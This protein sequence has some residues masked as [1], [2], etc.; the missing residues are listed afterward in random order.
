MKKSSRD[1]RVEIRAN[2]RLL[3]DGVDVT[4]ECSCLIFPPNDR[5]KGVFWSAEGIRLDK[6]LRLEDFTAINL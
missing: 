5:Y 1:K 2:K 6:E 3:F 4:S